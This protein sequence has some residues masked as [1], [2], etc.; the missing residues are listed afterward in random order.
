MVQLLWQLLACLPLAL[1][2]APQVWTLTFHTTVQ[3]GDGNI[4]LCIDRH[5][6]PL[7]VDRL[8]ELVETGYYGNNSFFRVVPGFVVQFGISGQ[9]AIS[10]YWDT[11]PIL[12]DPVTSSNLRGT[13][14]Y[15]TAGNNTRTTQLFINYA[16]N[17]FLDAVRAVALASTMW[18]QTTL[19]VMPFSF[20]QAS[21]VS[22]SK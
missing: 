3:L 6:A 13:M 15:A 4:V 7:G 20:I 8:W 11:R 9:P 18:H 16:D 14:A 17:P 22:F 21:H 10:K 19:F 12:D 1:A 5:L 2:I